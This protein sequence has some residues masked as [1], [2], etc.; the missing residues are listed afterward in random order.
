[1]LAL[2]LLPNSFPEAIDSGCW[3]PSQLH[4]LNKATAN[5]NAMDHDRI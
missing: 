4:E 5:N 1:M 2:T 3:L